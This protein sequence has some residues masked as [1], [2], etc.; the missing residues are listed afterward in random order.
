MCEECRNE[1]ESTIKKLILLSA[2]F[3]FVVV[4]VVAVAV[5]VWNR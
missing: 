5:T 4:T 1:A 2:S 3:V